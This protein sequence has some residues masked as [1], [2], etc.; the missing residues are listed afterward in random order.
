ME[1]L[2]STTGQLALN[3]YSQ[4]TVL[5]TRVYLPRMLAKNSGIYGK[6][7]SNP[8]ISIPDRFSNFISQILDAADLR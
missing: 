7:L 8:D 5:I 6:E 2:S 3:L 1:A 4:L